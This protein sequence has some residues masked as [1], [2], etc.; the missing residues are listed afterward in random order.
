MEY[1]WIPHT[2]EGI[3]GYEGISERKKDYRQSDSVYTYR[4]STAVL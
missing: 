4:R 1:R 3:L 2:R